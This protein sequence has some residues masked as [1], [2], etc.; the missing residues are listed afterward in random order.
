MT[1]KR[2]IGFE[3]DEDILV[4]ESCD[5]SAATVTI[6]T[7]QKHQ[8]TTLYGGNKALS[9][10]GTQNL[11]INGPAGTAGDEIHVAYYRDSSGSG[12][13]AYI[14]FHDSAN[15]L[16]FSITME[17]DGFVRLRKGTIGAGT[18]LGTSVSTFATDRWHSILIKATL[19]EAASSG[20]VQVFMNGSGTATVDSGAGVDCRNTTVD[21][22]LNVILGQSGPSGLV[23]FDDYVHATTGSL[24]DEAL[25]IKMLRPDGD[26]AVTDGTPSTGVTNFG[27]V[28][29]DPVSIV[30]YNELTVAATEDRFTLTALGAVP[31]SIL[32]VK[33]HA[34]MTGQGTITNG[35]TLI[36]S[37]GTDQ[38]GT[39][40]TL[41]TGG[42]YAAVYDHYELNPD[43]SIAW[44]QTAIDALVAGYE[45]NS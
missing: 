1:I 12:G 14:S 24:P 45:A 38:Y 40:Q 8:T 43:G 15:N 20:R 41:P 36:S 7:T 27:V 34:H 21:D 9:I 6:S 32:C 44:T 31:S 10:S 28:D 23:Y 13:F 5:F 25:Y 18:L 22:F 17:T 19:R 37:N 2:M 4:G 35:R 42:T 30:D 39:N 11:Q 29:E 33:A 16:Q 26:G 3:S